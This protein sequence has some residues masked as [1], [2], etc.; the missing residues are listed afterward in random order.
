MNSIPHQRGRLLSTWASLVYSFSGEL[1]K[2]QFPVAA[3]GEK[4]SRVV[5]L[6][7]GAF[8]PLASPTAHR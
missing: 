3:A 2:W 7:R 8:F 4:V 5:A 6:V 1:L